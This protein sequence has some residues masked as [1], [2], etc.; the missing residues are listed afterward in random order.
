MKKLFLLTLFIAS[1]LLL[2][3]QTSV[4][5][6]LLDEKKAA[7]SF[8]TVLLL[9]ADSTLFKSAL[10]DDNGAF[11]F[12]SAPNG[13]YFVEAQFLG[14]QKF[15][16]PLFEVVG[17]NI[18]LTDIQ[19]NIA[20]NE[21]KELTVTVKKPLL[22][23]QGDKLI[24]NIESSPIASQG[25]ALEALRRAP[26]VVVRQDKEIALRGKNGVM[27]MI[28]DKI[29]QMS[30]EDLI[31]FLQNM[32]ASSIDK[33]E[34][35][36][37]PSARYDA[38]GTGGIIN[39]KL[40][41]D[42]NLGFNGTISLTGAYGFTPK[43]N[44]NSNLN[45]RNKKVNVFANLGAGH[46]SW[47][48]T[49]NFE[50]DLYTNGQLTT[51]DQVFIQ[52]DLNN[53]FNNKVGIDFFLSKNTTLGV[54]LTSNRRF[55]E[56]LDDNIIDIIGYNSDNYTQ[57]KAV[58][59]GNSRSSRDAFNVNLKHIFDTLGREISF[60]VD[61]SVYG[62]KDNPLL[63][64]RYLNNEKVETKRPF[65][66]RNENKTDFNVWAAKV[67][68]IRPMKDQSKIELGLK[69]SLVNIGNSIFFDLQDSLGKW[70]PETNRNND[71]TFR[72]NIN[73]AYLNYSRPLGKK[74]NMQ[75]GLRV[76]NTINTGTSITLDSTLTFD[77]TRLFPSMNLTYTASPKHMWNM[78]YSLR[79]DR[80]DYQDLN[81]FTYYI[82]ELTFGRGN[83]FLQP[84]F[85]QSVTLTHTFMQA[86][87]TSVYYART[88]NA[89]FEVLAQDQKS[90]SGYQ[91][92]FNLA[93]N[94][95]F[96]FTVASPIPIKKWWNGYVSFTGFYNSYKAKFLDFDINNSSWSINTYM[97]HSFTL[98]KKWSMEISG[99]YNS[100]MFWGVFD[101]QP[102]ASVD[103]GLTKKIGNR[104]KFKF[105]V[106]DIFWTNRT[107]G[108]VNDNGLIFRMNNRNESRQARLTYSYSF[109]NQQVKKARERKTATEEEMGRVKK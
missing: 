32:P 36:N 35:I 67:D 106:Q 88:N 95:N 52:N 87:S 34:V 72:E 57:I 108:K 33:I 10:S 75:A 96:S 18:E 54:L 5:G 92:K 109:G 89:I 22:E 3:A 48:S 105:S 42:K 77:Y 78:A 12:D 104:S 20:S 8:A 56:D 53:N 28:D 47:R 19:L 14:Y 82:D 6:K 61:Y 70:Q 81:P 29:T 15:R 60:D 1:K 63:D 58:G 45:Y 24:M 103:F 21:L 23:M 94:D 31:R 65:M 44:G 98:P 11:A 84:Q 43:Y 85:T 25:T 99:W 2:Q 38:A 102:Q 90:R 27:V 7:L 86:V 101:I 64:N 46:N 55:G 30:Q 51:F 80:P 62:Q 17:K 91:T 9:K 59:I 79:I 83:P 68:Y 26:G 100:R 50:R 49:Q 66:L 69:S 40:K 4:S 39:I 107:Q 76:E 74:W 93:T 97:E 41:K 16:S 37:N 73:A 71:F 13:K